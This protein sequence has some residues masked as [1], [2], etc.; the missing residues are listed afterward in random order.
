VIIL[1]A[2]VIVLA[3]IKTASVIIVPFLLSLFIAIIFSPLF[4]WLKR[5]GLPDILSLFVVVGIFIALIVIIGILVG[6]S[7]HDFNTNLPQYEANLTSQL[8]GFLDMLGSYGIRVP[9]EE[10]LALFDPKVVM[11]YMAGTLKSFGSIITNGMVVLLTVVFLLLETAQFSQKFKEIDGEKRL[12]VHIVEIGSKIK[13]YMVL[14][15]AISAVTGF[16]VYLILSIIGIDYAVLWGVTAFLLNFIPNIGSIIAAIP[17]IIIATLE[18]G[19]GA[20]LET[21]VVFLIVNFAIGNIIEPRMMG[22]NLGLSTLVVFLSLLFWGWILG[23]VGMLLS[24][25]LTMSLKIAADNSRSMK[26]LGL[27][28]GN[29][30]EIEEWENN[31][32]ETDN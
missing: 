25:P 12:H 2:L 28:L 24:V 23:P 14:K 5:R 32:R 22:K 16:L 19:F 17:A 7:V 9:K 13:Q 27:F 6:S 21:T 11:K 30:A 8:S 3:G 31:H 10:M 15:T 4:N 26:S 29:D 20:A 18:L 1:A